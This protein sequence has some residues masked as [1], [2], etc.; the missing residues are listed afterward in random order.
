M[1]VLYLLS[2]YIIVFAVQVI[3]LIKAV[4]KSEKK[5]WVIEI[6]LETTSIICSGLLVYYFNELP[7]NGF[8]PGLTY[9]GHWLFSVGATA[10]YLVMFGV[11]L[12]LR[13]H[14]YK[15]ILGE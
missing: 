15:G 13:N 1:D 8:M 5:Y 3:L 12:L 11:T 14:Y 9:L 10:L 7:G 4:K 2:V 6:L